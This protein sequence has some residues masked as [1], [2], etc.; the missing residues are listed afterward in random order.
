MTSTLLSVI[1]LLGVI[2]AIACFVLYHKVFTVWYFDL[3]MGIWREIIVCMLIGVALSGLTLYFWWIVC[4]ILIIAAFLISS[5]SESHSM[6]QFIW[7]AF[8]I[9]CVIVAVAGRAMRHSLKEV[10]N[11]EIKQQE[12]RQ[13]AKQ[14][15]EYLENN[16]YNVSAYFDDDSKIEFTKDNTV[17]LIKQCKFDTG[18]VTGDNDEE[19]VYVTLEK[20]LNEKMTNVKWEN[21]EVG[22]ASV[23][24][25]LL[26]GKWEGINVKIIFQAEDL[27]YYPEWES[28]ELYAIWEG[29]TISDTEDLFYSFVSKIEDEEMYQ[30]DNEDEILDYMY[31]DEDELYDIYEYETEETA[32]S[33][34]IYGTYVYDNE[35]SLI[36]TTSIFPYTGDD[37]DNFQGDIIYIE[38]M[39]YD[40]H[41]C[42]DFTGIL[43][44][45]PGGSYVAY[46]IDYDAELNCVF[47][48][49]GV[50]IVVD[51]TDHDTL[52]DIEGFYELKSIPNTN[53]VN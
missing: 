43:E 10:E 7:I 53:D 6:K 20:L 21:M 3:K 28:W 36:C 19:T 23:T 18:Q 51:T 15:Q 39:G 26:E 17:Q 29:Q 46:C 9:L 25:T 14:K 24:G 22:K 40:G 52:W 31:Q 13:E 38:A 8:F 42:I 2:Y 27:S 12:Y 45:K 50:D 4:I 5:K 33:P 16:M 48:Y 32:H 34:S 35:T 11:E 30:D 47:Q 49:K 41:E 37:N 44:R 1:L